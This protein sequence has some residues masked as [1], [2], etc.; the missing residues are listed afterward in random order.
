MKKILGQAVKLVA[1]FSALATISACSIAPKLTPAATAKAEMQSKSGSQV[2]GLIKFR[3]DGKNLEVEGRI[4]GLKPNQEHGFHIHD[5]GDCSSTDGLSAGGHFNPDNAAHA[6]HSNSA[7]HAGD[8]PNLKADASGVAT[9]R[10]TL[11]SLSITDGKLAVIGRSLI[12]HLNPDDYT[13]QP[14]GN[15]GA[16][17][18]CALIE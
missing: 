16:R 5:K 2:A 17:I 9:F 3:Q 13:S 14:A 18:G 8:L 1:S 4:S 15:S 7:H 6:H 11:P 10:M 12:V